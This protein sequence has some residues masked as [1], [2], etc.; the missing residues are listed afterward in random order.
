MRTEQ[1]QR[2]A[3][4]L[5]DR[6]GIDPDRVLFPNKKNPL[7]AWLPPDVL[8]ALARG[9]GEFQAIDDDF[10]TFIAPLNQVVHKGTVVDRQGRSFGA[11]GVATIGEK[12]PDTD[13]EIDEHVLARGRAL[14]AALDLAGFNPLRAGL[15]PAAVKVTRIGFADEAEIRNNHLGR[16]HILAAQAG[17]IKDIP[18]GG[19]DLTEYRAFLVENYGTTTA[20]S[21]DEANRKSVINALEMMVRNTRAEV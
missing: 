1:Q 2:I 5:A 4:E 6:L 12:V 3:S 15:A 9:S 17:L 16:I 8:E 20:G 19:K 13:E 10:A 11:T 18:G 21:L 14:G 7:K